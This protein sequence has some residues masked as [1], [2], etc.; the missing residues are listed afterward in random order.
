MAPEL[1]DLYYEYGNALL[2]SAT[3]GA[4]IF[5]ADHAQNAQ[6]TD[7]PCTPYPYV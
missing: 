1:R 3:K 6:G 5:G 4:D 7:S 2:V